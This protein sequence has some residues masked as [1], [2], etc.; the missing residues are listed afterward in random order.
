MWVCVMT[1]FVVWWLA[2]RVNRREIEHCFW[3]WCNPLWLTRLKIPTD[4]DKACC[5]LPFTL[6][7]TNNL[8]PYPLQPDKDC[9]SN[10]IQNGKGHHYIHSCIPFTPMKSIILSPYTEK[11]HHLIPLVLLKSVIRFPSSLQGLSSCPLY[12]VNACQCPR[13]CNVLFLALL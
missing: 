2:F 9:H 6:R 13:T 11:V 3:P 10:P 8:P 5:H 12:S 7:Q 1:D 4:S